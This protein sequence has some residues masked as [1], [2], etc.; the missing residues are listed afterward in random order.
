MIQIQHFG[1]GRSVCKQLYRGIELSYSRTTA[2]KIL[3]PIRNTIILDFFNF[4]TILFTRFTPNICTTT[5]L[6]VFCK[7]ERQLDITLM[8]Q[9]GHYLAHQLTGEL[10]EFSCRFIALN[11]VT[12]IIVN[13][14]HIPSLVAL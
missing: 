3:L 6:C 8:H 4:Y 10:N 7:C 12:K 13:H 14:I 2:I 11:Y 5:K 9:K 1:N